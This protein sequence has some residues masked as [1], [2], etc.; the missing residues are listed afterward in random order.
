MT[1]QIAI[2][3]QLVIPGGA[4]RQIEAMIEYFGKKGYGTKVYSILPKVTPTSELGEVSYPFNY[5]PLIFAL[6]LIWRT[7]DILWL[8]LQGKTTHADLLSMKSNIIEAD[9][10]YIYSHLAAYR[11]DRDH[12]INAFSFIIGLHYQTI[13]LLSELQ[14]DLSVPTRYVEISSP[15]WR[16]QCGYRSHEYSKYLDTIDRVIVPTNEIG[17][18]LC[19]FEGLEEVNWVVSPLVLSMP[20]YHEPIR[21]TPFAFGIATRLSPEKN[22]H[23]LVEAMKLI[24]DR[25]YDIKLVIIGVGSERERIE[26]LIG[27]YSLE[28][29][30]TLTGYLP[31]LSDY[32]DRFDVAV[33]LSDVESVSATLLEALYFGKPIITTDV[34]SNKSLVKEGV[35]G[36]VV[37]KNNL[38]EIAND[39]ITLK[40]N[41][42][43]WESMSSASRNHYLN[44]YNKNYPLDCLLD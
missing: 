43:L 30:V 14:T 8:L 37:D 29:Y 24:R 7:P 11:I 23:L 21:N 19:G 26:T 18:N 16:R 15:V 25:G 12:R 31:N 39:I 17:I 42:L 3:T 13:W 44:L 34:G 36:Y 40:E 4:N 5:T 28:Q 27:K 6:S 20:P 38:T 22:I 1:K 9:I 41:K 10:T 32:I 2:I 33:L 35:N